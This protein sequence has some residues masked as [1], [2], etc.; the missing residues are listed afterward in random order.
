MSDSPSFILS[1]Q[2][3]R[4]PHISTVYSWGKLGAPLASLN[5]FSSRRGNKEQD[6][7]DRTGKSRLISQWQ[8]NNTQCMGV[9]PAELWRRRFGWERLLCRYGFRT[10]THQKGIQE[11]NLQNHHISFSSSK[12]PSVNYVSQPSLKWALKK[13]DL[14]SYWKWTTYNTTERVRESSSIAFQVFH[15]HFLK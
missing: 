12:A 3:K 9:K 2:S 6:F 13:E 15:N 4:E 10:G 7:S 14:S 8:W 11:W 5:L 1:S